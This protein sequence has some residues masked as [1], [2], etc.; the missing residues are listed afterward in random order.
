MSID[1]PDDR[2]CDAC[3]KPVPA[4]A[5]LRTDNDGFTACVPAFPRSEHDDRPME[6]IFYDTDPATIVPF[7]AAQGTPSR[8]TR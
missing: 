1:M 8:P 2:R 3:G 7:V 5:V 6:G 4:D